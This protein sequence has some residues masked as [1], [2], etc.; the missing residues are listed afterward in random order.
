MN[1]CSD[2]NQRSQSDNQ[3]QQR[4]R[5]QRSISDTTLPK[6]VNLLTKAVTLLSS[7]E[8]SA[9]E[10]RKK[11]S[12][13]SDD[14][15][16]IEEVIQ[17]LQ[18][19]NWQSDQRFMDNF[20]SFRQG[21]WGNLKILQSLKTHQLSSESLNELKETLKETELSRALEVWEKKFHGQK[22][23]TPQ[24]KAKQI[25]FLSSRGFSSEV[26]RKIVL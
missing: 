25:R 17:R 11:L 9:H 4:A 1:N 14:S 22:A 23:Q 3:R 15:D 10:L 13:Y 16:K 18:K 24:E 8:Y 21:K 6:E 5:A 19:E 12:H 20:V 26:I 7:R 2:D